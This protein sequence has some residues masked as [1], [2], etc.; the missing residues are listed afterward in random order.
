V[1]S[2][3]YFTKTERYIEMKLTSLE[4]ELE[5]TVIACGGS[6]VIPTM[7]TKSATVG[8]KMA[9]QP[10][11]AFSVFEFHFTKCVTTVQRGF[12]RNFLKNSLFAN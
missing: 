4:G 2:D 3:I 9:T 8:S 6:G 1:V 11:K 7:P 10:E 5:K 12:R